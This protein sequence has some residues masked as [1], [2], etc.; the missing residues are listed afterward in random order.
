MKEKEAQEKLDADSKDLT[1]V[2]AKQQ[3][4][5]QKI[6]ECTNKIAELGSMP[7]PEMVNKYM[8]YTSKNVSIFFCNIFVV[9]ATNFSVFA[10]KVVKASFVS[11]YHSIWNFTNQ[12]SEAF[13][14]IYNYCF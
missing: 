5:R 13:H 8:A 9:I 3:I 12:L 2:A 4:L 1:K 6:D 14:L 10:L 7:Q 11:L